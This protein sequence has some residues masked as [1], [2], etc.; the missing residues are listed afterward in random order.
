MYSS[1]SDNGALFMIAGVLII[2]FIIQVVI[3]R[4]VFSIDKFLWYQKKQLDVLV[5]IAQQ[6]GV[7]AEDIDELLRA[8]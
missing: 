7:P 4:W 3:I 5:R 6:Q 8:K 1:S 2:A